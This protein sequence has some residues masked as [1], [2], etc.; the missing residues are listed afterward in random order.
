MMRFRSPLETRARHGRG[1]AGVW[2]QM[3]RFRSPL[4]THARHGRGEAGV[5][6]QM[7]R[8]RPLRHTSVGEVRWAGVQ[9]VE[10]SAVG[11][12]TRCM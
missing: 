2:E 11:E 7:M 10:A 5:W 3:M 6:E 8:I 4:E 12:S 1:E 9:K